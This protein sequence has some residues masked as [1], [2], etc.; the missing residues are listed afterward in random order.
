MDVVAKL[1][2]SV[3][4]LCQDSAS[5]QEVLGGLVA[6]VGQISDNVKLVLAAIPNLK[7]PSPADAASVAEALKD[8]ASRLQ[9]LEKYGPDWL[10]KLIQ[11]EGNLVPVGALADQIFMAQYFAVKADLR[12]GMAVTPVLPSPIAS[13]SAPA[14]APL[15][16]GKAASAPLPSLVPTP[17]TS[18]TQFPFTAAQA[19]KHIK[20]ELPRPAKFSRIAADSDI[21]AWL[22]RI[23][24]YLTVTGVELNVWVVFAGSYLDRAP[25]QL[26]EARKATL[27]AQPEVLY[28]WE[29][30]RKW[31]ISSFSV[32]NRERYA[33]D[34]LQALYQVGSV[35]EYKAAHNVLAAQ[36]TLPMQLR[37]SWWEKGLKDHIRSQ[38][39]VDP[40]TYME[41]TDIDKAQ[42]AACALDAYRSPASA[43][44]SDVTD[45][46]SDDDDK[47]DEDLVVSKRPCLTHSDAEHRRCYNCG[48]F[49]H[50]ARACPAKNKVHNEAP[51]VD[52]SG[53]RSPTAAVDGEQL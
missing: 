31:C 39:K 20:F 29:E 10:D 41:F 49:G 46:T 3:A 44:H 42:S 27:A 26:W 13:A 8:P 38:V 7:T 19:G 28:S 48:R 40:V 32:H 53:H 2:E 15:S 18:G 25:L 35:A 51:M 36:T 43:T 30:F 12:N 16:I 21:H 22:V 14:A 5:Q 23:H 45:A 11:S 37:I 33:L 34:Q 4:D 52:H 17:S 47:S 9:A 50:L 6:I 24:E 1:Q